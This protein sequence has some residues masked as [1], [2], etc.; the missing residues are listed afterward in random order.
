M[1]TVPITEG[2]YYWRVKT[3][4]ATGESQWLPGS[5]IHS[6]TLSDENQLFAPMD[7]SRRVLGIAWQLQH[8]DTNML[9]LDGDNEEGDFAWDTPHVDRG[10]HGNFY[11]VRA[12]IS[13]MASYYGGTLSQD[14]ISYEIFK[15]VD[16][17]PELDLGHGRG[18]AA[19]PDP[20]ETDILSWAVGE[21][22]PVQ[23]GKPDFQDIKSWI[24]AGQPIMARIP[25]HMRVIDGYSDFTVLGVGWR[26]IHLL[27]PWDRAKWVNYA[28]DDIRHY[29]VGPAGIGGA[30]DVLSDEDEDGDGLA[31]TVDDSDGDGVCDFDEIYNLWC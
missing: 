23:V 17:G 8:K 12:A 16:P 31:D 25:G 22:I 3:I 6:L 29:W 15:D 1:P 11:C 20:I 28:D 18:V 24:D 21:A 9:C 4:F 30:P 27:D 19:P 14:R 5:E 10:N 2:V 26:F 13:M 7:I